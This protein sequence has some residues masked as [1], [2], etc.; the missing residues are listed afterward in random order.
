MV[1]QGAKR[2]DISIVIMIVTGAFCMGAT[3]GATL[4]APMIVDQA[5]AQWPWLLRQPQ[6]LMLAVTAI[7]AAMTAALIAA[8]PMT[9]RFRAA[10][11]FAS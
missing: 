8:Q 1:A 9:R 4:I 10:T 6:D 7:N 11:V 3:S 5:Q 2:R